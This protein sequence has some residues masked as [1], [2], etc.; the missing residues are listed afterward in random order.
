MGSVLLRATGN[1]SPV[2]LVPTRAQ[3]PIFG[4]CRYEPGVAMCRITP[5][6]RITAWMTPPFAAANPLKTR[7]DFSTIVLLLL[8]CSRCRGSFLRLAC[9]V[10]GR[11]RHGYGE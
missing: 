6:C 2:F 9:A 8:L 11:Q 3:S 5:L 4:Y 7:R 1:G 10:S